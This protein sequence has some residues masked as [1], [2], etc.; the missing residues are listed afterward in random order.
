VCISAEVGLDV[1]A[2]AGFAV[3]RS[4]SVAG[5]KLP[6][7]ASEDGRLVGVTVCVTVGATLGRIMGPS[8]VPETGLGFGLS[9]VNATGAEVNWD[10]TTSIAN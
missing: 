10:G 2:T 5:V 9:R 1:G 4:C 8:V 3:V 7:G 6:A